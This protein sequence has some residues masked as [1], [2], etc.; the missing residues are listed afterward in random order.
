MNAYQAQRIRFGIL[1]ARHFHARHTMTP[2]QIEYLEEC[3]G[4]GWRV[5]DSI[6]AYDR[7][8]RRLQHH[9]GKGARNEPMALPRLRPLPRHRKLHRRH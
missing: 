1:A 8:A 3:A 6:R 5:R 7:E 2:D 9:E 4:H